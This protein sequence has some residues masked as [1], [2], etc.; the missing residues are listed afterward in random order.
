MVEGKDDWVAV[1][2]NSSKPVVPWVRALDASSLSRASDELWNVT[3]RSP[4]SPV[5]MMGLRDGSG[6]L[7]SG[8]W[9]I[10]CYISA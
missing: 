3:S 8:R 9:L 6:A 7:F 1:L 5:L 2:V 10:R 4:S